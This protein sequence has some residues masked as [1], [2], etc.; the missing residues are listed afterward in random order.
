MKVWLLAALL[1][2]P[3]NAARGADG[4]DTNFQ[5]VVVRQ[6]DTL[7]GIAKTYLKDPSKWDQILKYNR[8]PSSDPTVA[9][10]GMTLRV[11]VSLIKE[12]MRAA[13][14]IY[15][16]NRVLF[17]RRETADWKGTTENMELYR[18]DTVKTM[19]ASKAKVRFLN[20]DLLSLDP[21]S[22]ATIKP[23]HEDYDV[24]LKNGGLFVGHSRVVTESA[25]ITPKTSDTQYSARVKN[26]LST[27]VEV[28]TGV[29]AVEGQG[30]VVDVKAG[31][32]SEV[33]LGLAPSV[34]T[35]IADLPDFEARA[36]EF[37]GQGTTGLSRVKLAA[38]AQ[39]P[40]GA[41]ADDINSAGD[42]GGLRA[43]VNTLS[44]GVPISGYRVQASRTR[45]FEKMVFD[46]VFDPDSKI[47]LTNENVQP[48]V[49]WF[50]IALVDLLGVEQ[51]PSAPRLYSVGL[52]NQV[53]TVGVD[54]K[55]SIVVSKPLA[56]EDVANDVYKVVGRVSA[57][58]LTVKVNG[59]PARQDEEGNFSL[60][61]K[62]SDGPN[63]ID[64]TVSDADG[65][66]ET[67]SRRVTLHGRF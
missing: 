41:G 30:K 19:D 64:V 42:A 58:N 48:G 7:W 15:M 63:V 62:L 13:K 38:G 49:Y 26:D 43:D 61:I 17:R 34:P 57:D 21:N 33:K 23:L 32:A 44:V 35:K 52:A 28:Y 39:L 65:N 3:W 2:L 50:R 12:S 25:R 37:N 29:A 36:A 4:A 53:K 51:A 5:S 66:V 47:D 31:M 46:K 8:L 67:V 18:G 6:G 14:L 55:A 1:L 59:K 16:I 9:L 22:Q 56:D 45:N 24:F 10:P 54:L 20:A 11:P 60:E 27:V 40:T